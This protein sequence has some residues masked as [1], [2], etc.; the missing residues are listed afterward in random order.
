MDPLLNHIGI[1]LRRSAIFVALV[2]LQ[3]FGLWVWFWA[4]FQR[5]GVEQAFRLFVEAWPLD[6][7]K[8]AAVLAIGLLWIGCANTAIIYLLLGRWWKKRADVL[9]RRGS[10]FVDQREEK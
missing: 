7:G 8:I 1:V 6:S 5:A 10:R 9:H 3:L 4:H 2:A